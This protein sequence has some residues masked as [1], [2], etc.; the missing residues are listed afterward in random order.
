MVSPKSLYAGQLGPYAKSF[1]TL[2][3]SCTSFSWMMPLSQVTIAA[4]ALN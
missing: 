3:R 2:L 1:M 4:K